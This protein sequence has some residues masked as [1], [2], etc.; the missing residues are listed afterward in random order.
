MSSPPPDERVLIVDDEEQIRTLLARVLGAHVY[1]CITAESA[2]AAR[3]VLEQRPVALVL[4][5]VCMPGD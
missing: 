5:Y 1:V 2:A 4:S 3:R